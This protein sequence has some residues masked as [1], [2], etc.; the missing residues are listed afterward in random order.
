MK[1]GAK[2]E[3]N[4]GAGKYIG[5]ND[6]IGIFIKDLGRFFSLYNLAKYAIHGTQFNRIKSFDKRIYQ[7]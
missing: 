2:K 3:M 7:F 1:F 6:Y 5:E 4:R